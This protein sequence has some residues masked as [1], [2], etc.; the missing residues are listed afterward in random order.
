MDL[1]NYNK[2][3]LAQYTLESS[4]YRAKVKHYALM[5]VTINQKVKQVIT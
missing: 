1:L 3:P 5:N 2:S 4:I